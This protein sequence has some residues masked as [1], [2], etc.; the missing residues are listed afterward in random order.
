M[1]LATARGGTKCRRTFKVGL[2]GPYTGPSAILLESFCSRLVR[3]V[4]AGRKMHLP[5]RL[6]P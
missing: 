3:F 6:P 4:T 5:R 1:G 2:N